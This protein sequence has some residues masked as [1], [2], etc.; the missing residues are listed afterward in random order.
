M[1]E[2]LG[3]DQPRRIHSAPLPSPGSPCPALFADD[4]TLRLAY[5]VEVDLLVEPWKSMGAQVAD[6]QD[7]GELC[8]LISFARPLAHLFGPP[9]DEAFRGHPL[10][11]KGLEPYSTSE[12][13]NSSWLS[14]IERMNSVHP[15]HRADAF[16]ELKHFIF[17]FHD[18]TF[19][20]IAAGFSVELRCATPGSV[21]AASAGDRG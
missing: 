19:E 9:N 21:L 1:Y 15:L 8:A 2:V 4:L 11:S 12:V 18:N 17:C 6:G 5:Y 7:V 20:C 16:R 14:A 3:F 10:A 13:E